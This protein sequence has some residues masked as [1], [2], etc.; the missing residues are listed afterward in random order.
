M[1][2]TPKRLRYFLHVDADLQDAVLRLFLAKV[3]RCLRTR[4]AECSAEIHIGAVAFIHRFG[5]ALNEHVHVH[6]CVIDSVFAPAALRT[7]V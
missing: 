3:E 1:L 4:S 2:S 7:S 5:F 6:C